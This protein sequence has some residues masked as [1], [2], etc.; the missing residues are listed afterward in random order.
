MPKRFVLLLAAATLAVNAFAVETKF[1]RQDDQPDFEKGS[2]KGLSLRSDGRLMLAPAVSEIF[3]ASTPYL[4]AVAR[5]SKGNVYLGGG[6]SEASAAHLY[7]VDAAGKAS[8]LAELPGVAIQ[9]IAIDKADRVFAATSPDGKVYE[10]GAGGKPV[11]FFEPKAKYIWALAFH[12]KDLFVATGDPGQI[13]RVTPDGKSSLFFNTEETHARSLAVDADGNLLVGTD[14]GGLVIRVSPSGHGFVVYQTP[15]SEVAALAVAPNGDVYAAALGSKVTA[16]APSAP[17][18]VPI[19]PSQSPVVAPA[20]VHAA[21]AFPAASHIAAAMAGGSEVYRIERDG[22]TRRVWSDSQA[23]VYAIAFDT[24]GSAVL[25]TGNRGIL[26]RIDSPVLST[27]LTDLAPTQV[28]AFCPAPGG[29]IYAITGNVGKLYRIGPDLAAEGTFESDTLDAGWFSR[30]G[31]LSLKPVAA[32]LSV[33]TRSGNLDRPQQN[34]S[35]WQPVSLTAGSGVVASPPARFL[36]YKLALR[37]HE[38][39]EVSSVTVAYLPKNVP[40]EIQ[41][42]EITPDNYRFPPPAAPPVNQQN[43]NL[44][45]IGTRAR[46]NAGMTMDLGSASSLSYAKGYMGARWNAD[47][48][49]GDTLTYKLEIRGVNETAWRPLKAKV[50][51]KYFSWDSTAFADGEYQIR[52]TASDEVSNP[53]ADA[54]TASLVSDPFLIDN[55]PPQ[56]SGAAAGRPV[57]WKAHDALNIISKAEYSIDGGPW[58]VVEPVNRLS[59]SQ[60][61]EYSL[62]PGALSAGE[63]VVAVRV[64]DDYDNQ[65][66]S[67][68]TIP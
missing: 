35:E 64:T 22:S 46:A 43:L 40:P 61:E 65:A 45:P 56:I 66:V 41:E 55:T 9:A 8:T 25:G 7:K 47:D 62:D 42:I 6:G 36:Q 34:W 68:I 67:Q 31:R 59:D 5:D 39:A 12:G 17:A 27:R 44:P 30:W 53:P 18:M 58:R 29:S 16:P 14:P 20:A 32:G 28:T 21:P 19:T 24:S 11:V 1:W 26:Y 15:K 2:L 4:W 52:V 3:D 60:D 48:D 13:F 54:L 38:P 57:R 33:S 10:I 37:G 23:L 50:R 51:E 49:N 63:H